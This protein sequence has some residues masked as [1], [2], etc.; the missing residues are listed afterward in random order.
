MKIDYLW[1]SEFLIELKNKDSENVRILCDA[2]LS[3]Y[4]CGDMMWRNPT[5]KI[6]YNTIWK[7]DAI[8][9]S[10]SHTDHVDPY[11][12]IEL[13][14]KLDNKLGDIRKII[15]ASNSKMSRSIDKLEW[16][17]HDSFGISASWV[18]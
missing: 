6:D 15:D 1:H 17:K 14:N 11:T 5:F 13:Y 18:N 2:W 9:L 7:I 12:L 8:Y 3:D 10:H 4:A 16:K